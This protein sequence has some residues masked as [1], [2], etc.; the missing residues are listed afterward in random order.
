MAEDFSACAA[1]TKLYGDD[2][3]PAEIAAWFEDEREASVGLWYGEHTTYLDHA[4]NLRHGFRFLPP[5]RLDRV[6]G[7][8]SA[9]GEEFLPI[10]GRTDAVTIV[11][12]SDVYVRHDIHGV[13][14]TY[15]KPRADGSL[16]F[17]D[18]HFVLATCF[19][20]LHHIPNVSAV[21]REMHRCV[22]PGGHLLIHEPTVSMG[23]WTKPR[24]GLTKRE[25]GIPYRILQTIVNS[26]GF[27]VVK[28]TRC[29]S[30][31]VSRLANRVKWP[32]RN[33][34]PAVV[35]DELVCRLLPQD[36]PYHPS[37]LV[38][39]AMIETVYYVLKKPERDGL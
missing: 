30:S 38:K 19:G 25:R 13:P 9:Y 8:G 1:G 11:E 33:S 32:W 2:F 4:A 6:L 5:G 27:T 15:V 34:V 35:L 14:A 29:C 24:P 39:L 12:P 37:E 26:A 28:E 22:R 31:T 3:G 16:P 17:P 23:D 10:L 21:V 36:P 7:L 18:D 20:V